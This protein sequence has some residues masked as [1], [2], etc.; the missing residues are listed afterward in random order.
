M[1]YLGN[2][3]TDLRQIHTDNVFRSN[4]FEGQGQ[5]HQEQKTAF[6]VPVGRLRAVYVW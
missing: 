6:F 2:R 5:G 3:W 1:N 4:E